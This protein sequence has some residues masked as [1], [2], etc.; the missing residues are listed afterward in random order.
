MYVCRGENLELRKYVKQ[1]YTN[2]NGWSDKTSR[3]FLY[4]AGELRPRA[5]IPFATSIIIEIIIISKSNN[6]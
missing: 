4:S 6:Q 3:L 1:K 2:L 5:F